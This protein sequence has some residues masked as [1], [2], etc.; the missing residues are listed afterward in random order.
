M[1]EISE[2]KNFLGCPFNDCQL[3]SVLFYSFSL[4]GRKFIVEIILPGQQRLFFNSTFSRTKTFGVWKRN[5]QTLVYL[6]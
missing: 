1:G 6:F 3:D 4:V 2:V 5:L